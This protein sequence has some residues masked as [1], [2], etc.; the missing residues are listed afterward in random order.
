MNVLTCVNRLTIMFLI[1]LTCSIPAVCGEIHDAAKAGDL[2]KVKALL[3]DN[4]GLVNEKTEIGWTPLHTA[5]FCG[6]K[7]VVELLL[8]KGAKVNAKDNGGET[9]LHWAATE[10]NK[11]VVELFLAKGAKVN[12][13]DENSLTPLDLATG[14]V[15]RDVAELLRQHGGRSSHYRE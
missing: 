1:V 12:A 4:P 3:T 7:D 11:D 13:K 2:A 10:G 14:G 6:H 15:H 9:P 8:A 5:A